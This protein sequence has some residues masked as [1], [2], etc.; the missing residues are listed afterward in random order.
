MTVKKLQK[1]QN[2]ILK[3]LEKKLTKKEVSILIEA[4]NIE[5]LLTMVEEGHELS[6]IY[7]K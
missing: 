2:D 7:V 5:Y 1:R 6:T 3:K 4:I